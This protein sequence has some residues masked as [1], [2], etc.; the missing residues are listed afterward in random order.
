MKRQ[1]NPSQPVGAVVEAAPLVVFKQ[2]PCDNGLIHW[3]L[4]PWINRGVGDWINQDAAGFPLYSFGSVKA[5][6]G[7][8]LF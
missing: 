8:E 3:E 5:K 2:V 4:V 1:P 6:K 7:K